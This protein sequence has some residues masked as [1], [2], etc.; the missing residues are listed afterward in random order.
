MCRLIFFYGANSSA[1][2]CLVV[3]V[4]LYCDLVADRECK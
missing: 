4:L 3:A 2:S 1:G